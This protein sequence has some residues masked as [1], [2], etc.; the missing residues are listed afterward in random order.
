MPTYTVSS[1]S[2][3]FLIA[4]KVVGVERQCGTKRI[5]VELTNGY[6]LAIIPL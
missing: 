3:W 1:A 4:S 5:R 2:E 6:T